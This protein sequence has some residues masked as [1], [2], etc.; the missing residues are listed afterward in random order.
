MKLEQLQAWK[1]AQQE[2]RVA[3]E[4]RE[5]GMLVSDHMPDN[6]ETPIGSE[7]EAWDLA[8]DINRCA[9]QAIVNIYVIRHDFKPVMD[10]RERMYRRYGSLDNRQLGQKR[11][12]L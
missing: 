10:Y 5:N 9:P 4:R 3:F 11:D 7:R 2:Y 12:Q 1:D 8:A 6:D